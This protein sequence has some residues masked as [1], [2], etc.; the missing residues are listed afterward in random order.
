MTKIIDVD[1][2]IAEETGAGVS[3]SQMQRSNRYA[4]RALYGSPV[5]APS[6]M[7]GYDSAT[8]SMW[9]VGAVQQAP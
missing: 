5:Y 8:E 2:N 4:S 1:V 9:C 6:A 3:V 7:S